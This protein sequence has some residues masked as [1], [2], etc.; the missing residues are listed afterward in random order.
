M[1]QNAILIFTKA[2]YT[3]QV[4]TRLIPA[5]GERAA[6]D[7]YIKLLEREVEWIRNYTPYAVE[8]WVTPNADHPV[9]KQ[10][11]LRHGL[12]LYLQQGSDLGERMGFATRQSLTRY[13]QVVLLGVDCPVL[14]ADHLQQAFNWLSAGEDAVL[15]PAEDGGYVLL[16]LKTYQQSLFSGHNWGE[17]DVAAS[18]RQVFQHLCWRW[19]E[20]PE[21]WD[22]DR[23]DD[24]NRLK[25]L[26]VYAL[27]SD[28]DVELGLDSPDGP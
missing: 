26:D 19:Q 22:L 8:L 23:P 2:P 10:L 17:G 25:E 9:L 11:S 12:K 13:R 4:K 3:G 14:T 5:I 27:P 6:T 28:F 20:L 21:L 18:T 15:G 16:G 1:K 7:L 24:L